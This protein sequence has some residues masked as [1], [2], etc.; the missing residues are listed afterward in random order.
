[1]RVARTVPVGFL[2]VNSGLGGQCRVRRVTSTGFSLVELLIA[3]VL[4][5]IIMTGLVALYASVS[6]TNSEMAK[7]N[8]LIENGRF[9]I[10]LLQSDLAHAG[11][12][13][14]IDPLEAT[15]VP[16]PCL[17]YANSGSR[18][19]WPTDAALLAAYKTNLLAI[20]V[21]GYADGSA[22]TNCGVANVAAKSNVLIVRHAN[23]CVAGSS[24][25]DGGSDIVGPHIQQSGCRT[26]VPLEASYV[27]DGTVANFTLKAKDCAT[28]APRRKMIVNIYYVATS[29]G[30]P[31]LM[32]VSMDNGVYSSPEPLVDGIEAFQVEYG[33]DTLGSNGLAISATNP[34][35]GNADSYVSCAPDCN[36]ATLANVVAVKLHVLARNLDPT[37]GYI[38]N[39]VYQL[40]PLSVP[41]ANDNY[42]RHVFSTT[43]RLV[44]TSSRRELP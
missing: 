19:K 9:A 44:N 7:T 28:V 43:V 33:I 39:K 32:R 22:L 8:Q 3:I 27:L 6:R 30:Q 25:C 36:L 38:A 11:F 40:G 24:G 10:Q 14:A 35:D 4:S 20:P 1:M 13:G 2:K 15:A 37:A 12:W 18:P 34:G 5:L 21:H 31:T 26:G 16:D 42:K 29:N 41:A 17:S 23:T